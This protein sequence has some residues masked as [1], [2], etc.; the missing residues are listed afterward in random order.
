MG[1]IKERIG[2]FLEYLKEQI[3]TKTEEIP[4]WYGKN[5]DYRYSEEERNNL[6]L[7]QFFT[8]KR[9]EIFGG[10]R[11][12]FSF[13]TTWTVPES[14][15]GKT[16]VF[17]LETGKEG[18]WDAL[19]PQFSLYV[20]G[21][22][23]QG[24]DVN[25]RECILSENA[26]AGDEYKIFLTCFTGDQNYSLKMMGAF[27]ILEPRVEKL[28]YDLSVPYDTML[29]LEE[30]SEE[31]ITILQ[32]INEA[33]NLVDFRVEDS[34]AFYE[35]VER[36]IE[37][38][39]KEFYET[40]CNKEKF[41]VVLSVGHT[42][43]DC[44][45]LWTLAVTE[46]KAVRSFSTVLELMR[47]YPDYIFMSSQP[48]LYMYVKKN[49]PEIYEEIKQRVKE[50]RWEVEGGMFVE[51]DCNL[52][53]GEALTRQF[54]Y[55]KKFFK[56]EFGK[57]NKILWLPDVFGY[58]A[59]LPQIMQ[60]CG[61]PY[62]MTT[63]ISWNETNKMPHDSFLWEGID[64]SRCLTHFIPSRDYKK[65]EV[66]GGSGQDFYTTYNADLNPSQVKG[67]WKRYSDKELNKE[68]LCS[69]GYGDG[70]GGPTKEMLEKD[71][72]MKQ[73]IPGLPRTKQGT[74]L[75]FYDRLQ[76]EL[77][78]KKDI[79]VWCGELYL[80]YHRGTYTTMARN[81][82]WNRRG[83]FALENMEALQ[84]ITELLSLQNNSSYPRER[85]HELWLI[86]LRNQFHDILPG[87]SI[88]EVYEDSKKEYHKLFFELEELKEEAL[89]RLLG[90]DIVSEKNSLKELSSAWLQRDFQSDVDYAG[91]WGNGILGNAD[92]EGAKQTCDASLLLWNPKQSRQGELISLNLPGY[93][94][95]I[96]SL[97]DVE[98]LLQK[99]EQGDYLLDLPSLPGFGFS[100]FTLKEGTS[101]EVEKIKK[102]QGEEDTKIFRWEKRNGGG[103]YISNP[104]F[105]IEL[106]AR[107]E[108][109]SFVDLRENREL[110]AKGSHGNVLRVFE[111]RPHNYDAWDINDYYS[112]K[113]YE[114]SELLSM[115]VVEEG[116]LRLSLCIEKK[117]LSSRIKQWIRLY[118]NHPKVDLDFEV[119][120]KEHLL[121][122][123][124]FF[125]FDIQTREAS[126]DIQYGN[127]KRPTHANTS[128]D[129]A[130]FEVCHHKWM[131]LSE[132]GFGVS[133]LN[134]SKFGISVRETTVGLSLLKSPLYPNPMADKEIHH[135]SYSI[136]PHQGSWKD[137]DMI[138]YVYALN[139]PAESFL[140]SE[141]AGNAS[142]L[143]SALG[144]TDTFSFVQVEEK[145]IQLECLKKAERENAYILRLYEFH[146]RRGKANLRFH[147]PIKKAYLCNLLEEQEEEILDTEKDICVEIKPFE[148]KT[149]KLY[150]K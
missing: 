37:Y 60:K 58:S 130:K 39:Q 109:V 22:L 70:G 31:Y 25:H 32:K 144:N 75:S 1:F 143:S 5:E 133:I 38:F 131:D 147:A 45:W 7:D 92:S 150:F 23:R 95:P 125:S 78:E 51:A 79:P 59:A 123:K 148:I 127:V 9:E 36:A 65:P 73:G 137:S 117:F 98:Y 76:K 120:W 46:D 42:H 90:N 19:N 93:E 129:K 56:E 139:N 67:S 146:G 44:A 86:L 107:G 24:L 128:W 8:L 97:G 80:E 64:G 34:P 13:Y 26:K 4:Y 82:K 72:R 20:N 135:F 87:S 66:E 68:V 77:C 121:L 136:F 15:S 101:Q 53:S 94:S 118:K 84:A 71:I 91:S 50:G 105:E 142:A 113:P 110:L 69:F 124:N 96:V 138:S 17:S 104:F 29:L 134:D 54:L 62:F 14:F 122:L 21:V 108:F 100:K 141:S 27:R 61:V 103:L 49:A 28:Y 74:A 111:D 40:Y 149:L 99:G 116:P 43:I 89:Q 88:Y 114:V 12:Y 48:Q 18:A 3:Y 33:I 132:D 55:G 10:H 145:N 47:H 11:A 81:K 140:F 85:L 57:D 16:V 2:K 106:N 52:S 63:K 115:E 102:N 35:S 83:E 6:P 112:E 119:D 126:F 41:P 30:D